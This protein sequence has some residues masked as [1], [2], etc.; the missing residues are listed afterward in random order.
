M[1][2]SV[3]S[4]RMAAMLPMPRTGKATFSVHFRI[5]KPR[6]VNFAW[7]FR[8]SMI[9]VPIPS[10]AM[11]AKKAGPAQVSGA[12]GIRVHPIYPMKRRRKRPDSTF[13]GRAETAFASCL[14][15]AERSSRLLR[16]IKTPTTWVPMTGTRAMKIRDFILS[17]PLR[18]W[19][20]FR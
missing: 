19:G 3:P 10:A 2:K 18:G 11:A 8:N 12:S 13:R 5:R 7:N 15:P 6:S 20:D 1:R 17:I 14:S 16:E 9:P 4:Q